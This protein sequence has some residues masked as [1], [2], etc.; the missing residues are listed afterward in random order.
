GPNR[1]SFSTRPYRR[2]RAAH[3]GYSDS[4]G[5]ISVAIASAASTTTTIAAAAAVA[6]ATTAASATTAAIAPTAAAAAAFL[7]LGFVDG[8]GS[9]AEVLAVELVDGRL[10]SLVGGHL[11]EAESL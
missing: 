1:I 3:L 6:T 8:D 5:A 7:R 4:S 9:T 2:S 11:D 10:G